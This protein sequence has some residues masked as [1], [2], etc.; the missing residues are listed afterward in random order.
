V[1]NLSTALAPG[2]VIWITGLP[3][4]GKTTVAELLQ[5]E[6]RTKGMATVWLDGDHLRRIFSNR[7]GYSREERV[8]LA[9]AYSKLA[10]HLSMQGLTVIVSV[11]AMFDSVYK[12]NRD[13]MRNYFEV[14]LD[15]PYDERLQRDKA[16]EKNVYASS[17]YSESIY[18]PPAGADLHLKNW[19]ENGPGVVASQI[20]G[21]V[22]SRMTRAPR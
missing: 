18:D 10:A 5:H 19:G 6:F 8:E 14:F 17:S 21:H 7:W 20:A 4:S 22:V 12:Q 11:V 1:N 15:V 2:F 16:T 9:A 13:T 3:N